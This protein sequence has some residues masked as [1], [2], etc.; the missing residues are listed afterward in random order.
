M[1]TRIESRKEENRMKKERDFVNSNYLMQTK[2]LNR[3]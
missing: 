3:H 2:I 1:E